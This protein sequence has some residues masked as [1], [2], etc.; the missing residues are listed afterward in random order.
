MPAHIVF[1][2]IDFRFVNWFFSIPSHRNGTSQ[3]V[4]ALWVAFMLL[5]MENIF[6]EW[7]NQTL[8]A[9]YKLR[10]YIY[11]LMYDFEEQI[12]RNTYLKLCFN[13]TFMKSV[14]H[15]AHRD[16]LFVACEIQISSNSF[17]AQ[18]NFSV[19]GD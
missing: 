3:V 17:I 9:T 18:V 2:I 12:K 6:D 10:G 15:L 19:H 5:Y 1:C 13:N 4:L 8:P 11:G 7:H 16:F 14:T